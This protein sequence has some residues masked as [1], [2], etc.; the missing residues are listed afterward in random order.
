V[1]EQ[2]LLDLLSRYWLAIAAA[3]GLVW[4]IESAL[5]GKTIREA[6]IG[7][8]LICGWLGATFLLDRWVLWRS[9]RRS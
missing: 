7:P 5:E 4:A 3:A 1:N 6:L 9:S 2:A 8:V